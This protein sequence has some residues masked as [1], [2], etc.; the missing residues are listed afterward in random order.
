MGDPMTQLGVGAIFA[1]MILDRVFVF[2]SKRKNGNGNGQAQRIAEMH[3]AITAHDS[4]GVFRCWSRPSLEKAIVDL[5]EAVREMRS[6]QAETR[7]ALVALSQQITR[8]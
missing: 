5:T 4:D 6:E 8:E 3:K 2:M 7:A 1:L